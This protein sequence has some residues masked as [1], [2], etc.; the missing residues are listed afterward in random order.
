MEFHLQPWAYTTTDI[1]M[2]STE[3]LLLGAKVWRERL[4][5]ASWGP[6]LCCN[7]KEK[8]RSNINNCRT[9]HTQNNP[10]HTHLC[11]EL[12]QRSWWLV[13]GDFAWWNHTF[14]NIVL[15]CCGYCRLLA[16]NESMHAHRHNSTVRQGKIFW[17][18]AK[19]KTFWHLRKK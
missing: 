11:Q 19:N 17:R 4:E 3:E 15:K 7:L 9:F 10:P 13:F 2:T 8:L 5:N 18:N 14:D 1:L 12:I 16:F 6:V